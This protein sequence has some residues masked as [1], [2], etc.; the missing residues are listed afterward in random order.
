MSDIADNAADLIQFTLD[1]ALRAR[2]NAAARPIPSCEECDEVP[3]RITDKG[4]QTRYCADCWN[5][6]KGAE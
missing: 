3:A 4:V 2:R 1:N 5:Y 6:L